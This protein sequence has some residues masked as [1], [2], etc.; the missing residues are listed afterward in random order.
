MINQVSKQLPMLTVIMHDPKEDDHDYQHEKVELAP[1]FKQ[2]PFDAFLIG[3]KSNP[4]IELQAHDVANII[5]TSGTT[6][7]AKGV[8]QTYR[9]IHGYTV[10]HL[11]L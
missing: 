6:G 3:E 8:V 11:H 4:N 9:W 10:V 2:I 7:P 1:R 5:Y